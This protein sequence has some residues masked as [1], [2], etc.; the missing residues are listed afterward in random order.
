MSPFKILIVDDEE[1]IRQIFRRT[2]EK[3]NYAVLEATNVEDAL[4]IFA[5]HDV[6]L[7]ISDIVMPGL[8]GIEFLK[9]VKETITDCE[10][11][12]SSSQATLDHAIGAL[13]HGAF[14][15]FEKSQ[16]LEILIVAAEQAL[17]HRLLSLKHRHLRA[18]LLEKNKLLKLSNQELDALNH[19]LAQVVQFY[20]QAMNGLSEA[21]CV[22]QADGRLLFANGRFRSE[23]GVFD[24]DVAGSDINQLVP[25]TWRESDGWR[26]HI[27]DLGSLA[28][29]SFDLPG[30]VA[31]LR[32]LTPSDPQQYV[33]S[34]KL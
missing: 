22:F 24:T 9:L 2:F 33:L 25:G 17:E 14:F 1:N 16:P 30:G 20:E 27:A 23:T 28:S 3:Q 4:T 29:G 12:L 19:Q 8:D 11:I 18:E 21:I 10:V 26:G 7:V 6:D 31:E 13:N 34:I 32:V 5:R 15:L